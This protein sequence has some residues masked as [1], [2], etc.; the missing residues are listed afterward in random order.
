MV[1]L[2]AS[3]MGL[4]ALLLF[5]LQPMFAR[6]ALP[7]LGGAPAVWNVAMVFFQAALL[8]GYLYAHLSV[9]FMPRRAQVALH[10]MLLAAAYVSLPVAV[11]GGW[12]LPDG[13]PPAPW[14]L[15]LMTVSLGLPFFAVAT[16]APLLQ[17]WFA[18]VGHK[19]S[20]DP[21]FLYSASNLGSIAALVSYPLLLEPLLELHLQ[22]LLWAVGYAVLGFS[23]AACAALLFRRQR[24]DRHAARVPLPAP[25]LLTWPRRLRWLVLAFVPSALLLAVTLHIT[26]DVAAVPLLWVVPLALYLLTYVIVFARRP[27]PPHRW[28]LRLQPFL[29]A[30]L[31]LV[32][33]WDLVDLRFI[34]PLHLG[35]FFV[36]AMVCHGEL[37]RSRPAPTQ[38]TDFYLWM[39]VG[40]VLGGIF[41][42]LLAPAV[43]DSVA[44]YP[45]LLVASCLLRPVLR[46][47]GDRDWV[48]DLVLPAGLALVMFIPALSGPA[49]KHHGLVYF[50]AFNSL[51]CLFVYAMNPRPV[52][53]A[54]GLGVMLLV[55]TMATDNNVVFQTRSFFGVHTVVRTPDGR[56]HVLKHG[57]VQHG[58]QFID[59]AHRR[60]PLT[61]YAHSEPIGWL[62]EEMTEAGRL[63]GVGAVGLGAGSLAC[64]ARPGQHWTFFEIDPTV[65]RIA[66]ESGYFHYLGDCAPD[67]EI[68]L[69]D[70]RLSLARR[71]GDR[72]DLLVIDAFSSDAIPLHLLTREALTLYFRRLTVDGLLALH[73]SNWHLDLAPVIASL[74]ADAGWVA[75]VAS[76]PGR[77]AGIY[78]QRSRWVVLA[79]TPEALAAATPRE[80]WHDLDARPGAPV[81][82]DDYANIVKPMLDAYRRR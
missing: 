81:W 28:M 33:F 42:G 7:L 68:V 14:L 18:D 29:L 64:Y 43:F 66:R 20:G 37:A 26:T 32:M 30:V 6:M 5:W 19:H 34:L 79:R 59:P 56:A 70:G 63:H 51:I 9:R 8:A 13:A 52:R 45:L 58:A 11:A 65:V 82:R 16:T 48:F 10:L 61:Y 41:A 4:S 31:A 25:G 53:L 38:L 49:L 71:V 17:R 36:T 46:R 35:T 67:A 77:K 76:G 24:A 39:S 75:R 47:R 60:E 3:T 2:F 57:T 22:S 72:F 55:G 1:W 73:V 21:Y 54:A 40:G 69:G 12:T 27:W 23:I 74:A 62:I 50:V 44:E 78:R 15:A 80:G